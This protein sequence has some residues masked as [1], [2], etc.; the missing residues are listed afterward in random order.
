ME[1]FGARPH[2]PIETVLSEVRKSD[3]LIVI[4][5]SHY[6]SVVPDED[7]SFTQAEYEEGFRLGKPCLVYLRSQN[8][9]IEPRFVERRQKYFRLLEQFKGTLKSRHV[10]ATFRK[11]N[12][13][14]SK[15]E[16][17]LTHLLVGRADVVA[18]L[19]PVTSSS[20]PISSPPPTGALYTGLG[21]TLDSMSN[22]VA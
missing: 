4:V 9:P 2:R 16:R 14:A 21:K 7:I 17:D 6:G 1:Y 15:V 11:P 13:L 10:T 22:S 20:R 8:V 3:V 12:D 5:G 19:A 18:T